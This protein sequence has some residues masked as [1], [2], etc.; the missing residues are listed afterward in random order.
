[1][2]ENGRAAIGGH[3]NRLRRFHPHIRLLLAAVLALC[4]GVR[5]LTPAGFM[6]SLANGSL[7][8]VP[9]PDAEGAPP[10]AAPAPMTMSHTGHMAMPP[11]AMPE[12]VHD[13]RTNA[14]H[15]PACPY[16]SAASLAGLDPGLV[17]LAVVALFAILPPLAWA[18]PVFRRRATRDRPPAQ[19]PPLPA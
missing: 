4:L 9:C 12:R 11:G 3:V 16:A 6:P 14:F 1:V 7:A 18:L 15:H 13:H 17:V 10:I 5:V 2:T 8:I 19:A